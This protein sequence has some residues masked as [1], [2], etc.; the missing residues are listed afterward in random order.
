MSVDKKSFLGTGWSFPPTFNKYT[1]SVNLVTG[2][3]DVIESIKIILFTNLGE[4]VMRPDFG[5]DVKGYTFKSMDSVAINQLNRTVERALK[6]HEPRI[7][8]NQVNFDTSNATE[9]TLLINL[10]YT[11][12]SVNIRTNVV[13]PFYLKEGT[14]ITDM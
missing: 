6:R 8:L 7:N 2:E 13:F 4:R 12:K 5:S 3:E 10:D 9:G 1:K 11:I 14:H